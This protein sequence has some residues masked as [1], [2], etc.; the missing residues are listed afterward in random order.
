MAEGDRQ[1]AR[2]LYIGNM[3]W[4]IAKW[5]DKDAQL[6][7]LSE[8]MHEETTADKRSGREIMQAV[9]DKLKV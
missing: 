1:E 7:P 6:T 3:L 4:F 2:E 5:L 9:L 8:I